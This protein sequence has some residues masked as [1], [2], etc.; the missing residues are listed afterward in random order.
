ML[1]AKIK[2]D[3][4]YA[5][6][7]QYIAEQHENKVWERESSSSYLIA[8]GKLLGFCMAYEWELLESSKIL[9]IRSKGNKL[10]LE[11]RKEMVE[12]KVD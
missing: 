8:K 10:I 12:G 4:L 3:S 6:A 1:K 11:L 7:Y 2:E 9:Q 5:L